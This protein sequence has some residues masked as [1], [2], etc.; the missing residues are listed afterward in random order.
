VFRRYEFR[1][2]EPRLAE[3]P[4]AGGEQLPPVETLAVNVFEEPPELSFEPVGPRQ[5]G[6]G[7]GA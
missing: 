5:S 6:M 3:L 1:S 2:L 7:A 4:V